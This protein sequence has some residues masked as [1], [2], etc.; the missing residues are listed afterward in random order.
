[1]IC[2]AELALDFLDAAFNEALAV[3]SF[4]LGVS[5]RSPWARASAMAAITAGR[6]TVLRRC[7]SVLSFSAP[8]LV[9]EWWPFGLSPSTKG[10]GAP[11]AA[12]AG[13]DP[14]YPVGRAQN[15]PP[16]VAARRCWFS[17]A[18]MP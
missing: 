2:A 18:I 15:K 17:G 7:S 1:M 14:R 6:S 11:V 9:M 13:P 8:R 5:L 3:P 10:M 4:V 16:H 12:L